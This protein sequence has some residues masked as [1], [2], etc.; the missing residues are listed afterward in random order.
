MKSE[1]KSERKKGRKRGRDRRERER[2]RRERGDRE[3]GRETLSLPL[4]T[5]RTNTSFPPPPSS[6]YNRIVKW[7][8]T[9]IGMVGQEPILFRDTIANNIRYGKPGATDEEIRAV[10]QQVGRDVKWV[11]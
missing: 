11:D 5:K 2:E 4:V 6:S 3:R 7:L 10:C 9:V 1:R 8:R